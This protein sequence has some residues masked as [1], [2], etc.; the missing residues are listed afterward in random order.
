MA[1]KVPTMYAAAALCQHG[2]RDLVFAAELAEAQGFGWELEEVELREVND[3]LGQ[4][5]PLQLLG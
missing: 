4:E 2:G 1:T 5:S 3:L